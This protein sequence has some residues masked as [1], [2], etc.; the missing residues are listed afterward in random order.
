MENLLSQYYRYIIAGFI[1][2]G[3]DFAILISFTEVFNIYYLF[4]ACFA[5]A[6]CSVLHYFISIK[7]IFDNRT[8]KNQYHE[9]VIF[10]LI[11]IASIILFELLMYGFTDILKIHYLFS[12]VIVTGIMF[13]FNFVTRKFI[14]FR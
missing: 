8:I 7:F 10:I 11:G 2:T 1:V 5:F 14:L 12:K 13:T 6:F 3:F 9:F 4:S